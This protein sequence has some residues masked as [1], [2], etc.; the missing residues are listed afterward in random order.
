MR[1]SGIYSRSPFYIYSIVFIVGIEN[2]CDIAI[3]N[4][5]NL[6]NFD[7]YSFIFSSL[8]KN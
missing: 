6:N 4:A 2:T 3:T 5:P 8:L 1:A 7:L